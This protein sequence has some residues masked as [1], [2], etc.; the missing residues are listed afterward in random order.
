MISNRQLTLFV[1]QS[2]LIEGIQ[3]KP[4]DAEF[5][6]HKRFLELD[7][8]T[9]PDLQAFVDVVAPGKKLRSLEGMN[10]RVGNHIAPPGG[11]D[12][13]VQLQRLLDQVNERLIDPWRAH[14]IFET[15]H[16]FCDGNGRSGR[17]LWLW[18]MRGRPL[19]PGL[20]LHAAYYQAL[21][22]FDGR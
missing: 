18:Q 3:R 6:A 1:E 4:T 13:P 8:I 12:I 22:A 21:D 19:P 14:C 5:E 10:V 20:F 17:V 16:P 15:I 9:I 11:P 7:N 2:N